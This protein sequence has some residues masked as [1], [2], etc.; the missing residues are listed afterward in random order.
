MIAG[1]T[2]ARA[3]GLRVGDGLQ[4]PSAHP[5]P[6]LSLVGTFQSAVEIYAADV[7]LC[8]EA[9]ARQILGMRGDEATDLAITLKNP[10]ESRIV[11]R[12]ALDRIDASRVV[13]RELLG[14]VYALGYGRRAGLVLAASIPAILALLILAWDRASGLGPDEKREIAILKAVG[15]ATRDVLGVKMLEALLVGALGTAVGLVLA[16]AWVFLLG[17]PGLRPA[18]VGWSV[19]YPEA[20]LTP[21]VDVAQL[22]AIALTVLAP[23]VGLS[24]VPAWRA[25]V[26]DPMEAMR[27]G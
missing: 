5:S 3:L 2:L 17:A 18:L 26:I 9:D 14:R 20:P 25:A 24:I 11:A 23:F 10:E 22:L 8:D 7:L 21:M 27:G 12:T 19:L 4:L 1:V 15:F 6:L 16:Y 13:E